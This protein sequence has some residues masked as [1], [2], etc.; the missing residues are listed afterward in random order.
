MIAI[1]SWCLGWCIPVFRACAVD[2]FFVLFL[3]SILLTYCAFSSL[4][5]LARRQEEHP[6]CKELSDEV[7]AWLSVWSEVQTICI[8]VQL[9]PLPPHHRSLH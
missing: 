3:L 4:T 2:S 7:L 1:V 6:A 8:M 9:M 5:L